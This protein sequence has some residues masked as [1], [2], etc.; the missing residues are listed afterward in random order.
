MFLNAGPAGGNFSSVPLLLLRVWVV[1]FYGGFELFSLKLYVIYEVLVENRS[2]R[3][4]WPL[5]ADL[6]DRQLHVFSRYSDRKL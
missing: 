5:M 3:D 2:R 4:D 6:W 1:V